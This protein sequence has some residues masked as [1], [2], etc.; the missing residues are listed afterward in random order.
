MNVRHLSVYHFF[1]E[2]L[3]ILKFRTPISFFE[4]LELSSRNGKETRLI[5]PELSVNFTYHAA[6]IWN[7]AREVLRLDD[8]SKKSKLA[9]NSN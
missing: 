9:K 1:N 4:I 5:T 7:V 8:F 2:I 3:K 6:L